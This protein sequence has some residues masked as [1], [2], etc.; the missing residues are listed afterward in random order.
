MRVLPVDALPW[1]KSSY[2]GGQS[3]NCVE[4][5][6]LTTT[7][8]RDSKAPHSGFLLLGAAT[9]HALRAAVTA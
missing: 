6:T 5:A 8:V 7:V 2:S 4:V 9:W 1:R 3:G